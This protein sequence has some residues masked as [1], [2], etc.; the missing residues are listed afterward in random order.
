MIIIGID[1]GAKGGIAVQ[2]GYEAFVYKT[3]QTERD[4]LDFLRSYRTEN[5]FAYVEWIHPAIQGI[6]KSQMSKLYGNYKEIRMA[7]TAIEIPFED[8]KAADWQRSLG[9]PKKQDSETRTKW[10]NRLKAKAQQLFP[11]VRLTLD[12]CDAMLLCEYGRRLRCG[13][14]K[15]DGGG[16]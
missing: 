2:L 1:P 4:L 14:L 8:V 11:R 12:T 6:G 16:L 7:L 9:I 5:T 15:P 3:P 10:K 13:E